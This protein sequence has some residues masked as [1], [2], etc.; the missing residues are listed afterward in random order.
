M[1]NF[2][3]KT[4]G[5][6]LIEL[7]ITLAIAGI[8][9][10]IAAPSFNDLIKNNRMV[11]Q[12]NELNSSVS[13]AR[14]EAIK[15][16][17]IVTICN[18]ANQTSCSATWDKSNN[19]WIVFV[20]TNDDNDA[21]DTGEE[22]IRVQAA[23]SGNNKLSFN[24]TAKI[25]YKPSGLGNKAGTFTLCDDRVPANKYAKALIINSTGRL[26]VGI[27]SNNN[28]IVEGGDGNNVSCS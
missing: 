25:S 21:Q 24:N 11:S 26:R 3:Q 1:S 18:S 2:Y 14:S 20:D 5:F 9:A 10:S 13:L 17:A 7:M 19:G 16:G 12:L 22:I 8:L 15:R 28:G 6:T 23:L 27:D 4:Q